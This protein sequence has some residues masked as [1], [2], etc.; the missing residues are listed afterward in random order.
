MPIGR[1]HTILWRLRSYRHLAATIVHH[2]IPDDDVDLA[3][4]IGTLQSSWPVR[5]GSP[6]SRTCLVLEPPAESKMHS[7]LLL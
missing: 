3:S 1:A 5:R 4:S 2:E 6:V 7:K